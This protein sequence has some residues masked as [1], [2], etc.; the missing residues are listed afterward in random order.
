MS[1]QVFSNE[2]TKY[3]D[4]PGLNNYL[5]SAPITAILA[6]AASDINFDVNNIVNDP[7]IV[8]NTLSVTAVLRD[9][10]TLIL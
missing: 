6:G 5:I 10:L 9:L 4:Y 1:N 8:D 3:Y 7:T 2:R